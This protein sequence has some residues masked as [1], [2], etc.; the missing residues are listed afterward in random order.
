MARYAEIS[1][2]LTQYK[3]GGVTLNVF[4]IQHNVVTAIF[5][6]QSGEGHLS[7]SVFSLAVGSHI[8]HEYP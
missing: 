8:M 4:R 1:R 5:L 2:T 7:I 3:C 6:K